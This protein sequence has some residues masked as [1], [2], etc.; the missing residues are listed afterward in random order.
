MEI[1]KPGHHHLSKSQTAPR[2]KRFE[3]S[4]LDRVPTPIRVGVGFTSTGNGTSRQLGAG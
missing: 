2:G 4:G 1:M 3:F